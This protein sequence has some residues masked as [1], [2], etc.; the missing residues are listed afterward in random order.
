MCICICIFTYVEDYIATHTQYVEFV[1]CYFECDFIGSNIANTEPRRSSLKQKRA[2]AP[3]TPSV[4]C[5]SDACRNSIDEAVLR[6]MKSLLVD[7]A[8]S[9][10]WRLR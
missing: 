4:G 8:V 2:E 10:L 3:W 9:S 6:Q 5:D 1:F 7:C